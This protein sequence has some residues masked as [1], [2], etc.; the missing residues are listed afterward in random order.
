MNT[1]NH[2][3][4]IVATRT[5]GFGGSDSKMFLKVG[6]K[7]IESLSATDI[8]RIKVAAGIVEHVQITET[9]AMKAGRLFEDKMYKE[10]PYGRE[11]KLVDTKIY[12]KNFKLFAHADLYLPTTKV[13]YE[14]KYVQKTTDEVIKQYEAQLQWYYMLN[15]SKVVLLHGIGDIFPFQLKGY[16]YTEIEKDDAVIELLLKGIRLIDE[17]WTEI[18]SMNIDNNVLFEDAVLPFELS[19]FEELAEVNSKIKE[20][21]KRSTELKERV[22]N[23]MMSYNSNVFESE[24][25]KILVVK[26]SIS[27]SFDKDKFFNEHPEVNESDYQK[28]TQ[29]KS[30]L[31]IN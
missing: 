26:E 28:V 11:T 1:T 17:H 5:G 18:I 9:D 30:F 19:I 31:K 14:C 12:P 22:L 20:L 25:V 21:E 3:K 15:Q 10:F 2:Q 4:E 8:R 27:V 16:N 29:K 24:N 13:V 6:K 23:T 7:G